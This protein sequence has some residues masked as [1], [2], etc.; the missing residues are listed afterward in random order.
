MKAERDGRVRRGF[1]PM[2]IRRR[3]DGLSL[4]R[5]LPGRLLPAL[6]AS[7][8]FLAA[9]TLAG[10]VGASVLA[11]RWSSGAAAVLT[12]Q[13]PRPDEPAAQTGSRIDAVATLLATE[14]AFVRRRLLDRPA[15]ERLLAPWLGSDAAIALPLPAVVQLHLR[16]GA[17]LPPDLADRLEAAAPGTLL[18]RNAAWSDRLVLLGDSLQACAAVALVVVTAVAVAV[19]AV[20]TGAALATRRQVIEIVHG[21]GAGDG[22]IAGR[23]A[24]RAARLAL[25]GGLTGTLLSVPLLLELCRLAAPFAAA[26]ASVTPAAA[27]LAN[28]PSQPEPELLDLPGLLERVPWPLWVSLP[29][30]PPLAAAIGWG[31]AQATVRIWLRRL[32]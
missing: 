11:G 24:G 17:L 4:R 6:V 23:F 7:V 10:A 32:P 19:V 5:A 13:V 12:V 21:L 30:M 18:G 14:P 3:A 2:P 8:T 27:A 1:G 9:L 16:A 25:Y 29:L 28:T 15:V 26:A 20:A 31:T 22:Y